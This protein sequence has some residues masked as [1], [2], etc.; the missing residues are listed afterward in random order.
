ML[1]ERLV[2]W[3]VRS[4]TIVARYLASADEVWLEA[5]LDLVRQ[6]ADRRRREFEERVRESR[7]PASSPD[8]VRLATHVALSLCTDVVRSPTLPRRARW[9]VF[10]ERGRSTSSRDEVLARVA[11]QLGITP[12][13]LGACLLADMPSQRRVGRLK[14]DLSARELALQINLQVAQALVARAS[15]L[16]ID[17]EGHARRVVQH[18]TWQGL[19]CTVRGDEPARCRLEVSGPLA[20]LRATRLYGRGLASLVPVLGWCRRF[21]L[22]ATCNVNG[23]ELI[24]RLDE[25]DPIGRGVEPRRHDSQIEEAFEADV[26]R[27]APDWDVLREP[28]A[29]PVAGTLIF[30]DFA[31]G[32]QAEPSSRVLV[33]IVGWWTR[34]YLEMKLSR[35]REAGCNRLIVC[36]EERTQPGVEAV[37]G[38]DVMT[39]R[40]RVDARRVLER[41]RELLTI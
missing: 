3:D 41:A 21:H 26:R 37:V 28:Q 7:W 29:L 33:E 16:T 25:A 38:L 22:E 39:F 40:R 24:F 9:E 31:I 18:A 6:H 34:E 36:L 8:A 15:R 19:I 11:A 23:R 2:R 1:P 14:D 30:P 10:L 5:L 35:L 12:S 4:D 20:M 13:E 17:I 27:L 32:P